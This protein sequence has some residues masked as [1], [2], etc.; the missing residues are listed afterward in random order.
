MAEA[1]RK[2]LVVVG[3][4]AGGIEALSKLVSTLPEDFPA[5]I[6][7]AQHLDPKR[8]SRL[9]QILQQRTV[10]P[11]RTVSDEE[12]L[13]DG[14]VFVVPSNQHVNIT[15]GHIGMQSRSAGRS[16]PSIDLLLG[17]AAEVFG[18]RLVAVILTGT[19]ND[20]TDGARQV[21]ERGGTVVIQNPSTADYRGMPASLAPNTVDV[22]ANLDEIVRILVDLLA[23]L[24][25]ETG[26]PPEGE[27][28]ELKRLLEGLREAHGVDFG[29]YKE[30]T[31][32]RRLKRRMAATGRMTL[33]EYR[34]YLEENPDEYRKLVSSFLIKVTEFFRDPE[35]FEYLQNEVLP[36]LVEEARQGNR[37]LRIWSAGCA[38]GEEAYS[39]AIAL[40]E[41]LGNDTGSFN[42]RI[43]ATD[44]DA[45][46]VEFARRGIYS[47]SSVR[48]LCE[49]RLERYFEEAG[50]RYQ[51]KKPVRRM[52]V[53]GEHDL[54][55]RSPF[56][57]MDLCVSRNVLIYFA[58]ELQKRAL[59][60]FA[61]SLR[62]G[63]ALV[64]GKAETV[65]PL[66]EYF[67]PV[68]RQYKVYGRQ[69]ERFL[70]PNLPSPPPS[71]SPRPEAISGGTTPTLTVS[72]AK[73]SDGR[74]ESSPRV[75]GSGEDSLARLPMG[76]VVV[77]RRYDIRAINASARRLLSVQGAAVGEDFLHALREAPYAEVRAALDA[78]FRDGG[79]A[80]TGEFALE[81]A[82]TGE[83][84]YLRLD[85]YPQRDDGGKGLVETVMI[86]V[87]DI[88]REATERRRLA[89]RM[90]VMDAE[91]QAF[92]RDSEAETTRLGAQNERLVEANLRLEEANRELGE[93]N[94]ELQTAYEES[95]MASE[96]A[97]AATEEVETL[98]EELQA[99]NE[100]LETLNEELQAT[101]EE[102]NT[103]NEDLQARSAE[104][105]EVA[106]DR[107]EE[108]R[109][110]E[111]ARNRLQV[112]LERTPFAIAVYEGPD[113]VMR[114]ANPA[115][116]RLFGRRE[117][118]VVGK[119]LAETL[120]ELVRQGHAGRLREVYEGGEPFSG[121]LEG[122]PYDR[123]GD[124][125]DEELVL[126]VAIVPLRDARGEVE[127][128]LCQL[129][130]VTDGVLS[131]RHAEKIAEKAREEGSRLEAVL[132]GIVDAVLALDAEGRVLFSNEVFTWRFGDGSV[133]S[134][135]AGPRLGYFVPL[136]EGG[137]PMSREEMPQV[138]A[139]RGEAFEER[140]ATRGED[141]FLRLF[142]ARAH[143]FPGDGT[144][145]GVVVIREIREG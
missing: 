32:V 52:I 121:R 13:E 101:I 129:A 36:R 107:E 124:G 77:D 28:E 67:V 6:V 83:H 72:S 17:S 141:G 114:L 37:G 51:V 142:E 89:E 117:G 43:F 9:Q 94:E 21:S 110:S 104:L 65:H 27:E 108:R 56:P 81:D 34:R 113:F 130:D 128:V 112:I 86:S 38:T 2:Q 31:I 35:H 19:G 45:E 98:N 131:R 137:E 70:M 63:G 80:S 144:G 66:S 100:E 18:E 84:R 48:G 105:Q 10:L 50:G 73:T 135:E 54:S 61:Y 127:G 125:E 5:P 82:V 78:A 120:P 91:M 71:P 3:S 93:L 47:P 41:V 26:E 55:R 97:Q 60:L 116:F 4:S 115:F 111:N 8:E 119:P 57:N 40:S 39:L 23:G 132:E 1:P 76:A 85:C 22:V 33:G 79:P 92:R 59:Q 138:R 75:R 30:N 87:N 118:D 14:V 139:A 95:L 136:T 62:D 90:S 42:V 102:L 53:F 123:D 15:D 145:G 7:I 126:D 20:G 69:G 24:G 64:L 103:T 140:F 143:P 109:A 11:V 99:T 96:E 46:A 25:G 44:I 58:P 68:S 74:P 106:R 12:P 49:E 134:K 122:L 88:T 29:S 16:K 133:G